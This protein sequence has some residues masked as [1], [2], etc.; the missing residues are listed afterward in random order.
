MTIR[1][2]SSHLLMGAVDHRHLAVHKPFERRVTKATS[3]RKHMLSAFFFECTR[4]NLATTQFY[5]F[6]LLVHWIFTFLPNKPT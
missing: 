6:A 2:M 3:K 5:L 1:Q 4:E